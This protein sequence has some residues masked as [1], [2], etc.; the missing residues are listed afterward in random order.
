MKGWR[1]GAT[2]WEWTHFDLQL[3]L[4][5][6]WLYRLLAQQVGGSYATAEAKTL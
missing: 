1:I 3:T 4:L 2:F 5:A 6:S